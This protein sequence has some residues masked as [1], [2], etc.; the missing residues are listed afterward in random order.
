MGIARQLSASPNP[1]PHS[2]HPTAWGGRQ[3]SDLSGGGVWPN[4]LVARGGYSRV[5]EFSLEDPAH[6]RRG[7]RTWR[8]S[9]GAAPPRGGGPGK[10]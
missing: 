9:S 7:V 5:R 1:P 10:S 3:A 4:G 6:R 8:E 2:S